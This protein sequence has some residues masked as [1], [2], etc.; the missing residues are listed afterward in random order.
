MH[1][2]DL[3]AADEVSRQPMTAPK[4]ASPDLAR[5]GPRDGHALLL[6][7]RELARIVT[8]AV[9]YADPLERV[10]DALPPPLVRAEPHTCAP[11][12]RRSKFT[13]QGVPPLY[14]HR[15]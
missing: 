3:A 15:R 9:R 10:Q 1:M 12:L 5:H 4:A 6:A 11:V 2:P 14:R 13:W 7:T 8:R